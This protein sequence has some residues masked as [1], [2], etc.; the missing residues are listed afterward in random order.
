LQKTHTTKKP[1]KVTKEKHDIILFSSDYAT[2]FL[3]SNFQNDIINLNGT[4]QKV[5]DVRIRDTFWSY[6]GK[7]SLLETHGGGGVGK[8]T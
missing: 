5:S 6:H 1:K 3:H 2:F 8:I 7:I 4:S